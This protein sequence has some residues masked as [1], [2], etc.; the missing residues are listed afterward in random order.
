MEHL[1]SV[2]IHAAQAGGAG[3]AVICHNA[4]YEWEMFGQQA[5]VKE[6]KSMG[7]KRCVLR[8][9]GCL[10]LQRN[11]EEICSRGLSNNLSPWK[12]SGKFPLQL[13]FLT[14]SDFLP[15]ADFPCQMLV[16]SLFDPPVPYEYRLSH[17]SL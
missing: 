14:Q 15:E 11:G 7:S 3:H 2:P 13:D 6:H 17:F 8:L 10:P 9:G 5:G 12:N 1:H 16:P 4:L